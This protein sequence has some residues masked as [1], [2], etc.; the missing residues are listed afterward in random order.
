MQTDEVYLKTGL[1]MIAEMK[2]AVALSGY[3]SWRSE[4]YRYCLSMLIEDI[5]TYYTLHPG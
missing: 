1:E 2:S 4:A 3:I 5:H